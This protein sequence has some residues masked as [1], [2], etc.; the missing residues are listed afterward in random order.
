MKFVTCLSSDGDYILIPLNKVIEVHRE[1]RPERNSVVVTAN[2]DGTR[3]W[4]E[5]Y[6]PVTN[7]STRLADCIVKF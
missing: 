6:N 5:C 2:Q 3:N 1:D 7:G 4:Y